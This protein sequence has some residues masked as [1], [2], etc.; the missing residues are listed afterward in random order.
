[1][2][3][4]NHTDR[5]AVS[6]AERNTNTYPIEEVHM[7][8]SPL[9]FDDLHCWYG[10]GRAYLISGSGRNKNIGYRKG[11][12]CRLGDLEESEWMHLM[13]TL[14]DQTGESGLYKQ[15]FTWESEHILYSCSQA[16]L[17]RDVLVSYSYRLFDDEGWV[18]FVDFNR[19]FRPD[20]LSSANLVRIQ[21]PCCNQ[22][23]ETTQALLNRAAS[24][25][26]PCPVCGRWE[27][28]EIINDAPGEEHT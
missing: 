27:V 14:I 2:M 11:I 4:S 24:G 8:S 9:S 3:L 19:R 23:G 22:P 16:E 17:E 13:K 7:S 15:F 20:V 6:L 10:T 1:M 26:T 5:F 28:F 12:M 18:G 21:C 25:Q